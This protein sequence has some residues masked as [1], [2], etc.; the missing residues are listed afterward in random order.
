MKPSGFFF[1]PCSLLPFHIKQVLNLVSLEFCAFLQCSLYESMWLYSFSTSPDQELLVSLPANMSGQLAL[2]PLHLSFQILHTFNISWK[3]FFYSS[4]LQTE[5]LHACTSSLEFLHR[6]YTISL[7][8]PTTCSSLSFVVKKISPTPPF[9][10]PQPSICYPQSPTKWLFISHKHT[11]LNRLVCAKTTMKSVSWRL[12]ILMSHLLSA[13]LDHYPMLVT[14][15]NGVQ[16][17]SIPSRIFFRKGHFN[18]SAHV[19]QNLDP[20]TSG[21]HQADLPF[22]HCSSP[23]SQQGPSVSVS[24]LSKVIKVR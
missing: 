21:L 10:I 24:H 19:S 1:F 14:Q 4:C 16:E 2:S 23:L 7:E 11:R 15:K 12:P 3:Y 20:S 13:H 9:Y 5:L 17:G 18:H 8:L 22:I 6:D